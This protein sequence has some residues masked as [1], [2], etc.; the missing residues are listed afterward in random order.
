MNSEFPVD[1]PFVNCMACDW[2]GQRSSLV[3]A[4]RVCKGSPVSLAMP[5]ITSL[6]RDR[7]L[8]LFS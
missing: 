2:T 7:V 8:A 1:I 4:S 5:Q 6:H 3:G